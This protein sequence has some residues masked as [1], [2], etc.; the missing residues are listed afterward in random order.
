[1]CHAQN[2]YIHTAI[3]YSGGLNLKIGNMMILV[4]NE[5]PRKIQANFTTEYWGTLISNT[6]GA[7]LLSIDIRTYR[8]STRLGAHS[9]LAPDIINWDTTKTHQTR[10]ILLASYFLNQMAAP[11]SALILSLN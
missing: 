5:M 1:M 8:K 4:T 11:K 6:Y 3:S 7:P 9:K 10:H 2:H